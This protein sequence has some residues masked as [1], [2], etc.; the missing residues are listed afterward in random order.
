MNWFFILGSIV[1]IVF[2]AIFVFGFVSA[3][4]LGNKK[5]RRNYAIFLLSQVAEDVRRKLINIWIEYSNNNIKEVNNI[6]SNLGAD[7][8]DYLLN[9]LGPENRPKNFS[10]GKRR[11]VL[12]WNTMEKELQSMGYTI[13]ASKIITGIVLNDLDSVLLELKNN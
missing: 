13:N 12:S 9:K 1:F 10:S 5:N 3:A 6:S 8:L 7:N 4:V 11:D 2:F